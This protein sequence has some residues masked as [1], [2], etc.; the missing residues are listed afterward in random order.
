MLFCSK[1]TRRFGRVFY[2]CLKMPWDVPRSQYERGTPW[3]PPLCGDRVA[4]DLERPAGCPRARMAG[5]HEA[6]A[7]TPPATMA[8]VP[9]AGFV[10]LHHSVSDHLADDVADHL[11]SVRLLENAKLVLELMPQDE[12]VER[13]VP[14]EALD[15]TLWGGLNANHVVVGRA[16][17]AGLGGVVLRRLERFHDVV[18]HVALQLFSPTANGYL[19]LDPQK[20]LQADVGAVFHLV[21]SCGEPGQFALALIHKT[22]WL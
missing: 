19:A 22:P 17:L 14:G 11:G 8:V 15:Q 20:G 10:V 21:L 7:D 18:Q 16:G 6:R 9:Q 12:L 13:H 5:I 1:K 4:V 2:V 3:S